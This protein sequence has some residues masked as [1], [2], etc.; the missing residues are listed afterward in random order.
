M[1]YA[2]VET[3]EYSLEDIQR[4]QTF[5]HSEQI[6]MIQQLKRFNKVN[7]IFDKLPGFDCGACGYPSCRSLAEAIV[8]ENQSINDC[9]IIRKREQ[10]A[11]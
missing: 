4:Q 5:T 11:G 1:Q 7:E 2:N 8:D 6:N 9:S 3:K 10:Y